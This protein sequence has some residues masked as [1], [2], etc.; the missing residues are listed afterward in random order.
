MNKQTKIINQFVI[1]D[2]FKLFGKLWFLKKFVIKFLKYYG[3]EDIFMDNEVLIIKKWTRKGFFLN[4][5][6]KQEFSNCT[7]IWMYKVNF[8]PKYKS[9]KYEILI[10]GGHD[11]F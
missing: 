7:F 3:N 10:K 6:C 4:I 8:I 9:F 2:C 1:D 11:N 5:G